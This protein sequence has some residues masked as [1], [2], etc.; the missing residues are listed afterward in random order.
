MH[1]SSRAP[2][3]PLATR[4]FPFMNMT[5]GEANNKAGNI[6][7]YTRGK[8]G[9]EKT[10]LT[11]VGSPGLSWAR[12]ASLHSSALPPQI[13]SLPEK[14]NSYSLLQSP[15]NQPRRC[16]KR[17]R[18]CLSC[19]PPFP[20]DSCTLGKHTAPTRTTR[21]EDSLQR[22]EQLERLPPHEQRASWDFQHRTDS[23]TWW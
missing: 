11:Q 4:H 1:R 8:Q 7:S 16:R 15:Q 20:Q 23:R 10:R 13:I 6:L 21:P 19:V 5:P 3:T 12:L 2:R 9:S 18:P 22:R 14:P 17:W